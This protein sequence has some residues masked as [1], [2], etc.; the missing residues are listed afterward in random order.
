M[1]N[2][3]LKI[4]G[5][6]LALAMILVAGGLIA[7]KLVEAA[8]YTVKDGNVVM[9]GESINSSRHITNSNDVQILFDE[10]G[11]RLLLGKGIKDAIPD[12]EVKGGTELYV[13]NED[14]S[15]SEK[16]TDDQV[17]ESFLN[18]DGSKAYYVT[19]DK[20]LFEV[21][22]VTKE[23]RMLQDKVMEVALS[24]D[25]SKVAYHKLNSEWQPGDY[26]ENALGIAVLNLETVEETQVTNGWDDFFPIWT[27][28]DNKIIFYAANPG[29]LVSQFIVD[30]KGKE[31]KQI[32]NVGQIYYSDKT[33]DHATGKP[34]WSPDG[35]VLVYE[36]DNKIW[37]N[38]FSQGYEKAK[39]EKI[40]FGKSPKWV[41]DDEISVIVT[42]SKSAKN[43]IINVDKNGN[44]IK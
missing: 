32:S 17:L 30:L 29:G 41:N 27:P 14:G 43:G 19:T 1:K 5:G 4:S 42:E 23:K 28:D 35:K 11:S 40:A 31:R 26:Y 3:K 10:K 20:K 21:N 7:N 12:T 13:I 6:I 8:R 37:I 9:V 16:L 33:I 2:N 22:V 34:S 44:I 24:N 18:R 25:N 39:S 15:G 36:T 38:D